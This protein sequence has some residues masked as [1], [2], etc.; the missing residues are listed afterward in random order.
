MGFGYTDRIGGEVAMSSPYVGEIRMFGGNFAP[1]GWALCN[2]AT[3]RISENE[4]LY[5]LIGTTY[6]GD[7][8][9]DFQVP[10]L[11]SRVPVHQGQSNTGS[12]YV[13]AQT[14]GADTVTLVQGQLPVHSH[15]LI[16]ANSPGDSS[17][18][19]QNQALASTG[20]SGANNMNTYVVPD[21]TNQVTLAGTSIMPSGGSQPHD[22][23][24]PSLAINFIISL[25]GIFPSQD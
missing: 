11:Q 1:A 24:Q 25:Y 19:Q 23:I 14:G 22:N 4:T 3:L 2:G 18:P 9:T 7:G 6:G 13:L 8:Q 17:N 12:T 10:N 21:G 15:P 5:Q 16:V 20:P